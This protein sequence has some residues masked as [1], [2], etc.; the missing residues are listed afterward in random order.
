MRTYLVKADQIDLPTDVDPL[1][2]DAE[3][4]NVFEASLGIHNA[5]GHGGWKCW[6]HSDRDYVQGLND[7][8]LS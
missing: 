3:Y 8:G 1:W 5:S 6:W 7:D 2:A 4:A